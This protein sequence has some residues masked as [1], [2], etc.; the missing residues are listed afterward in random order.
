[1]DDG[2]RL[3]IMHVNENVTGSCLYKKISAP[4][5]YVDR[6]VHL[7]YFHRDVNRLGK[8]SSIVRG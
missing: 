7:S 2:F 6:F 8:G 1:M 3:C 4:R 5:I